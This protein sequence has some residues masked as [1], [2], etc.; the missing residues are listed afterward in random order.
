MAVFAG[1]WP[2][3]ERARTH[4]RPVERAAH[5]LALL[6]DVIGVGLTQDMPNMTYFQKRLR[7]S[8]LS[9]TP[10]LD[11]Q[12]RRRT[13]ARSIART[14]LRVLRADRALAPAPSAHTTASWPARPP[15][16]GGIHGVALDYPEVRMGDTQ[17]GR[18]ACKRCD[19]M[20]LLQRL[21]T[22]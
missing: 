10:R 3:G 6:G 2:V 8:R 17:F 13:P 1:A 19:G 11:W 20:A 7:F 4:D 18:V 5:D 15:P 9:P 14:M 21:A 16:R 12:T 22:I